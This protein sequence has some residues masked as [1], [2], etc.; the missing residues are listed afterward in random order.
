M[1][2]EARDPDLVGLLQYN[3]I[4]LALEKQSCYDYIEENQRSVDQD[5][6]GNP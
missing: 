3:R 6:S 5:P 1:W 2:I 4:C